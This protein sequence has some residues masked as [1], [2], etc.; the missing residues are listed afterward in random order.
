ME[1]TKD[2][3]KETKVQEVGSK[4]SVPEETQYIWYISKKTEKLMTAVY[5][6]TD[7]LSDTEPMKRQLRELGLSVLLGI[8]SLNHLLLSDRKNAARRALDGIESIISFLEI[9]VSTELISRM[10][11]DV[12]KSEFLSLQ[13]ILRARLFSPSESV[14]FSSEF[15][16]LPGESL[17][18]EGSNPSASAPINTSRQLDPN[19]EQSTSLPRQKSTQYS[20]PQN[21]SNGESKGDLLSKTESTYQ[22]KKDQMLSRREAVIQA[23]KDKGEA[24]IGEVMASFPG[25]GEKTIQREITALVQAGLVRRNG[26]RRWSKYSLR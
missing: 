7:F 16:T 20:P 22:K 13:E 2:T 9:A 3:N 17:L 4:K 18:T 19:R 12:L 8:H 21:R 14:V 11:A 26:E 6:L 10:N 15:F 23:I 24:T 5:M 1:T 25:T